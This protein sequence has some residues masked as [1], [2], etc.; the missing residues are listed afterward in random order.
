MIVDVSDTS[1]SPNGTNKK[2]Q[3]SN[4]VTGGGGT[5]NVQQTW[6]F[7]DNSI[8]NVY[9]PITSES[10]YTSVQRF[11]QFICPFDGSLKRSSFMSTI[12]LSGGTGTLTLQIGS[13]S[14]VSTFTSIETATI[15]LPLLAS[16]P[17]SFVFTTNT[18]TEGTRYAFLLTGQGTQ[19]FSNC[20]GTLLF[21]IS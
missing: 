18:M 12:A 9:L 6:G 11:N 3:K 8:R 7:Y 1:M 17:S 14:G 19:A 16:T 5:N 2:I 20:S 4:L 21:E 15:T 10:E 13:I